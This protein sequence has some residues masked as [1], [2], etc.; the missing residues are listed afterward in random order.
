VDCS[1][2]KGIKEC[3]GLN[4]WTVLELNHNLRIILEL[5]LNTILELNLNLRT[6]P[7]AQVPKRSRT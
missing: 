5:N 4:L 3:T 2:S 1:R 7:A 6:I